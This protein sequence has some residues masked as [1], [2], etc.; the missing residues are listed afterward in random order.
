MPQL[1]L[2]GILSLTLVLCVPSLAGDWSS[3]PWPER[4]RLGRYQGSAREVRT[5]GERHL[6]NAIAS[7]ALLS[8]SDAG[9]HFSDR[10]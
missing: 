2:Q 10:L 5:A 7:G 3:V 8:S 4:L 9:P 6:E 1:K